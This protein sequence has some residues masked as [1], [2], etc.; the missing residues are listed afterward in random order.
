MARI[1]TRQC[2]YRDGRELDMAPRPLN[3]ARGFGGAHPLSQH[4]LSDM[5]KHSS[6]HAEVSMLTR[7]PIEPEQRLS[8]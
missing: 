4:G 5:L 2:N 6:V 3:A 7:T 8:A 1:E